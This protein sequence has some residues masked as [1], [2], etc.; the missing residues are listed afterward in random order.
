MFT[1]RTCATHMFVSVPG[2]DNFLR[3]GASAKTS[4]HHQGA[5]AMNVGCLC[6]GFELR[7]AIWACTLN[8]D[9]LACMRGRDILHPALTNV[10]DW[11]VLGDVVGVGVGVV[12]VVL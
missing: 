9:I 8:Q 6:E 4:V 1:V 3:F 7:I 5:P 2:T 12:I 10:W 11:S